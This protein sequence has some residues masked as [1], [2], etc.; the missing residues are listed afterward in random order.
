MRERSRTSSYGACGLFDG[1]AR[2]A[3]RFSP[4]G[5][6][7]PRPGPITGDVNDLLLVHERDGFSGGERLLANR[8]LEQRRAH[9]AVSTVF[10]N[11]PRTCAYRRPERTPT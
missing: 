1:S 4:S 3:R 2:A 7:R 5:N 9:R 8:T 10:L 6:A 11:P